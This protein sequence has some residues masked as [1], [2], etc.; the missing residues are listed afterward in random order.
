MPAETVASLIEAVVNRRVAF[1]RPPYFGDAEPSTDP[2][3]GPVGIASL[4]NYF[5]KGGPKARYGEANIA[6]YKLADTV[7]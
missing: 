1:F 6:K 5:D 3:L 4:K 7:L 2:E